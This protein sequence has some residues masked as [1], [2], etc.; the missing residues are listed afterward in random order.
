MKSFTALRK[1]GTVRNLR[2]GWDYICYVFKKSPF[3]CSADFCMHL[4]VVGI[5]PVVTATLWGKCIDSLSTDQSKLGILLLILLFIGGLSS[6]FLFWG[7]IIDNFYR[8]KVS[9]LMQERIHEKARRLSAQ[10]Y[11]NSLVRDMAERANKVFYYGPAISFSFSGIMILSGFVSSLLS[12]IVLARYHYIYALLMLGMLATD[13]MKMSLSKKRAKVIDGQ[14]ESRRSAEILRTYVWK[15]E[16]A[17]ETKMHLAGSFFIDRWKGLTEKI[18]TVEY[19]CF[20]KINRQSTL[21]SLISGVLLIVGIGISIR[22]LIEGELTIG[23]F[24]TAIILFRQ[25]EKYAQTFADA[26]SS[27]SGDLEHIKAGYE[28]LELEEADVDGTGP[29]SDPMKKVQLKHVSFRYPGVEAAEALKDIDLTLEKGKLYAVVGENGAGKSTLGKIILGLYKPT[30]GSISVDGKDIVAMSEA[31]RFY[32]RSAVFQ[33]YNI[34]PLTVSQNITLSEKPAESVPA[35][36]K[37]DDLLGKEIGGKELSGGQKQQIAIARG[38]NKS[39]DLIIL[40]EPTSAMDSFTEDKVFRSFLD[41]S[42]DK[43]SV[44]VT[45]RLGIATQADQIIVLKD[46]KVEAVGSHDRLLKDCPYYRLLWDAG[47]SLYEINTDKLQEGRNS[48]A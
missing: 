3:I 10:V 39:S 12:I 25:S 19:T 33:D 7:E 1:N 6:G 26:L 43:I 32:R 20:Q 5:C 47:K 13:L 4:M 45:H 36:V 27:L 41:L 29:S 48:Y 34:Y 42:K 40:D 46:G 14:T 31:E 11:E 21:L 17:K 44:V 35:F 38:R 9:L 15:H 37:P 23:R 16:A 28:F 18:M 2:R 22:F 24:G 30:E 8:C